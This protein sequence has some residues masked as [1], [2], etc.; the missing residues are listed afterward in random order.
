M[1]KKT[2]KKQAVWTL[3]EKL[4]YLIISADEHTRQHGAILSRLAGMYNALTKQNQTLAHN[5][6]KLADKLEEVK[7]EALKDHIALGNHHGHHD[8]RLDELNKGIMA[9]LS[10]RT[11]PPQANGAPVLS[12]PTYSG[13][14][15]TCGNFNAVNQECVIPRYRGAGNHGCI[16]LDGKS[17]WR[18]FTPGR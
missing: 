8:K 18:L 13:H 2:A 4:A 6:V 10:L 16:T 5:Q 1:K 3:T 9:S 12:K 11:I 7:K 15:A 14:C 17:S